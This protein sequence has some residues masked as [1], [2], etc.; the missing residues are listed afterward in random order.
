MKSSKP[1]QL[2]VFNYDEFFDHQFKSSGND[3]VETLVPSGG[4]TLL[5]SLPKFLKSKFRA[6]PLSP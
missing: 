4:A 6:S 1:P 3:L 2:P 5:Y